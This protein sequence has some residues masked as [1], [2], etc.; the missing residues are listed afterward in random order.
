MRKRILSILLCLVMVMGLFPT[1]A[2]AADGSGATTGSGTAIDPYRVSTYA[3]MKRLLETRASYYIIV[4]GMDN[5]SAYEREPIRRLIAGRDYEST[6]PAIDIPSGANH[7]LE[8]ATDIWFMTDKQD[9]DKNIFGRLIDVERGSSLEITG[10]GSLRVEVNTL[11]A[12]NAIICNWGGKLTIDGSVTLSGYQYMTSNVATRPI[13]INGGVTNIKGGYIIGHNNMS[14]T[15]NDVTSAI[16]FGE[17]LAEGTALNISGGTIK[18]INNSTNRGNENSCALYVDNDKVANA[19][20]LTGGTFEGGMK[21]KTGKPLSDLLAAGYQFNDVSTNTVFDGSVSKTQKALAVTPAGVDSTVIDNVSLTVK[22]SPNERKTLS[23]FECSYTQNNKMVLDNFQVFPGLNNQQNEIKDQTTLYDPSADYTVMYVFK[24]NDGFSFSSDVTEHVSVTGGDFLKADNFGATTAA[25]RTILRVF[26][27]FPGNTPI[28][29]VTMN[30]PKLQEGAASGDNFTLSGTNTGVNTI[31]TA[32]ENIPESGAVAGKFYVARITLTAEDGYA[33]NTKTQVN[34]NGDYSSKGSGIDNGGAGMTVLVSVPVRHEHKYGE[35]KIPSTGNFHFRECSCGAQEKEPHTWEYNESLDKY[36]C[37]VCGH[38]IEG[39][40]N[41][42]TYVA[43]Y[44]R[45]PIAGE[46]PG[47]YTPAVW[48]DNGGVNYTVKSIDWKNE[49]GS[50]VT[51]FESGKIYTGTVTFKADEGFVFA[52][53]ING[54]HIFNSSTVEIVGKYTLGDGATTL[55]ATFKLKNENVV[56]PGLKAKVKL[57][58]LSDKVGQSL[59]AAE[60]VDTNLPENV[61]LVYSVYEDNLLGE[62]ITDPNYKVNV[63]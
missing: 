12:T 38:T 13:W 47:D 36:K 6:E 37:T 40:K 7:H 15:S 14:A 35:W 42:I 53:T 31:N 46:H 32:W 16:H 56:R 62:A 18:Q 24:K 29:S 55:T 2:F 44:P 23:D 52:D 4:D 39:E 21:M 3:E 48:I 1:M 11:V 19:I 5:D 58:T 60:L 20:H 10:T 63:T 30:V 54:D 33:F 28:D 57:P 59:P 8:I 61:A 26:V 45:S 49:D 27:N 43:A 34:L 51:T 22:K 17:T 50:D 25:S 41:R 9:G